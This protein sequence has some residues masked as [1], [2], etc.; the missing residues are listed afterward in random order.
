[1]G[2]GGVRMVKG[3]V[4]EVEIRVS[5]VGIGLDKGGVS[6]VVRRLSG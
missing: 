1:V 3:G 4:C 2:K 6:E 5:E